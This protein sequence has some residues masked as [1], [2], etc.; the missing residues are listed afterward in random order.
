MCFLY[1]TVILIELIY[2]TFCLVHVVLFVKLYSRSSSVPSK[3]LEK[4]SRSSNIPPPSKEL[5]QAIMPTKELMVAVLNELHELHQRRNT[6]AKRHLEKEL[7]S[8]VQ[9]SLPA[10][11]IS[12]KTTIEETTGTNNDPDISTDAYPILSFN[13]RPSKRIAK[14][15]SGLQGAMK[16]KEKEEKEREKKRLSAKRHLFWTN[17]QNWNESLEHNSEKKIHAG[18]DQH[19]QFHLPTTTPFEAVTSYSRRVHVTPTVLP[20]REKEESDECT[21]EEAIFKYLCHQRH[22]RQA[23]EAKHLF[24]N[25]W[26]NVGKT[27]A[28]E[29][30]KQ[31]ET[32]KRRKRKKRKKKKNSC[33]FA[34]RNG[35]RKKLR[36]EKRMWH[37]AKMTGRQQGDGKHFDHVSR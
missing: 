28:V 22:A 11:N 37:I 9:F 2:V 27:I 16:Q 21:S 15:T 32:K 29:P 23:K 33:I 19:K 7:L 30:E 5:E 24:F 20:D 14:P 13:L 17:M 26:K 35:K 4:A 8:V 25:R 10:K 36:R 6:L 3:E 31:T 12:K 1:H 34:F 18:T